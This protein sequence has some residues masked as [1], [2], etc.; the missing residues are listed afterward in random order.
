MSFSGKAVAGKYDFVCILTHEI[1]HGLAFTGNLDTN[2]VKTPFDSLVSIQN[3]APVFTGKYAQALNTN[4]SNTNKSIDLEPVSAG[5]GS[6]CY[7]LTLSNDLMSDTFGK[8][9]VRSISALDLAILEDI[10]LIIVGVA[11]IAVV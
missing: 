11:L 9:E 10:G 3:G 8:A 4:K 1:L 7:H 2:G 6:A 5:N